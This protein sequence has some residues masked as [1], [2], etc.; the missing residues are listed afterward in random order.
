MKLLVKLLEIDLVWED[1]NLN[2]LQIQEKLQAE[3]R[4]AYDVIVLPEMFTTGFTMNPASCA[5]RKV[6]GVYPSVSMLTKYAALL[7]CALVGSV[8]VEDEGKFYNRLFFVEP[9]GEIHS[10]NKKHLFTFAGEHEIYTPGDERLIVAFRGW[11][12]LLNICYDLRFPVWS[13]NSLINN[14]PAFDAMIY[15]AN[16]PIVRAE[17]WKTLIRARAIENVAYVIAVNRIGEDGN[18]HQYSGDS[19]LIN[20]RGEVCEELDLNELRE[21][22]SKFPALNDA[23]AFS[24]T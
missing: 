19:A 5:E 7:D 3:Q 22:R 1:V 24:L 16:W 11:N 12:I 21:F 2:L 13:R 20:Y 9:S 4:G 18:S 10:Y 15:V 17:V 14:Q 6:D 8:S 23:D